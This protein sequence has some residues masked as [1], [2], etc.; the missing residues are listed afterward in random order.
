MLKKTALSSAYSGL[1]CCVCVQPQ[2]TAQAASTTSPY[3]GLPFR[4]KGTP[5]RPQPQS[6]TPR[7]YGSNKR[8]RLDQ[9]SVSRQQSWLQPSSRG[10]VTRLQQIR[11]YATIRPTKRTYD[12]RDNLNWPCCHNTPNRD[13]STFPVPTP[14]EI[15]EIEK[16][17]VYEKHK[18]YELVKMYHPDRH[19]RSSDGGH[20][21]VQA[22]A[23]A[24]GD[25]FYKGVKLTHIQ[26]LERYRLVV[27]A[28]QILSD[29]A[30][31]RAYDAYGAGWGRSGGGA[32]SRA[33][34]HSRGY[35]SDTVGAEGRNYGTGAG[36]DTSPFA[37]A[38]WEDWERWYRRNDDPSMR[39]AYTGTYFNPNAFASF[40]ILFAVISGSTLR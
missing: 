37:N 36:D 26:K 8:P 11:T 24:A 30:K 3:P 21:N 31:R 13:P 9:E 34:R 32:T 7:G 28:H 19:M 25:M 20:Q 14:Y 33:D 18:F 4:P 40:V 5:P 27:Q 1:Q 23:F 39:Q 35:S 38:T 29:P 16:G 10:Q 6:T 15:F 2:T 22:E 17:G 12:F